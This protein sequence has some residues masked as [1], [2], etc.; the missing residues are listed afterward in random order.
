MGVTM[1]RRGGTCRKCFDR[2]FIGDAIRGIKYR[3][4]LT[5][6]GAA[7]R[8]VSDY[9]LDPSSGCGADVSSN[10]LDIICD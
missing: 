8:C 3:S 2:Y 4:G 1:G 7:S 5:H 9:I 10:C 6:T